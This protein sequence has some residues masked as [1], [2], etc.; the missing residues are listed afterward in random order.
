MRAR[1]I[2]LLLFVPTCMTSGARDQA[3]TIDDTTGTTLLQISGGER[4][5]PPSTFEACGET[6]TYGEIAYWSRTP[7]TVSHVAC[8]SSANE[9]TIG[10]C[11]TDGKGH[12]FYSACK[13]EPANKCDGYSDMSENRGLWFVFCKDL[14]RPTPAPTP[15]PRRRQHR[16]QR[17]RPRR[18]PPRRPLGRPPRRPRRRARHPTGCPTEW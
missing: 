16:R 10:I 13:E 8:A 7:T 6:W 17:R 12:N 9:A 1:C 18:Q 4:S 14:T 5:D 2:C 3:H 15:R 11:R